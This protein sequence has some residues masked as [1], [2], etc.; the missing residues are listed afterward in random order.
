MGEYVAL[1]R[2]ELG[3]ARKVRQYGE[4]SKLPPGVQAQVELV[5]WW[6][7]SVKVYVFAMVLS[8]NSRKT[9]HSAE[10]SCA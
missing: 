1:L 3:L 10:R 4:V 6:T 2:E 5:R 8:H 9:T 7:K